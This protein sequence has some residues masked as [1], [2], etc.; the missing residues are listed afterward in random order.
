MS[1]FKNAGSAGIVGRRTGNGWDMIAGKAGYSIERHPHGGYTLR[2]AGSSE[3]HG[4]FQNKPEAA[5]AARASKLADET[6]RCGQ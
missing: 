1:M 4:Q 6:S 2:R 3:T 5:A